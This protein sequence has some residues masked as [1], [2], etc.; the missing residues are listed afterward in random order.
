[1]RSAGVGPDVR[2][3]PVFTVTR[4]GELFVY[5][6]GQGV[7]VLVFGPSQGDQETLEMIARFINDEGDKAWRRR[8]RPH[9]VAWDD[10]RTRLARDLYIDGNTYKPDLLFDVLP[11]EPSLI[12]P[13]R[14]INRSSSPDG[15]FHY[16]NF[17][18]PADEILSIHLGTVRSRVAFTTPVVIP[19]LIEGEPGG[20]SRTWMSHSPHEVFTQRPG[21]RRA[22]GTVLI[23]GLG[24]GWLL[25]R[26]AEKPSVERIIVVEK[27]QGILD[28]VGDKLRSDYPGLMSKVTDW[29]CDDAIAH[30]GRHGLDTR[31]LLDIWEKG[32]DAGHDVAW[33]A[34]KGT[35]RHAWGW[36][37]RQ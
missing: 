36:A 27:D 20:E 6:L 9:A 4:N 2:A 24:L 3:D 19:M 37:E 31:H 16:I 29:I 33:Q 18:M 7:K 5:D 34:A 28:W 32:G 35:V 10:M 12:V 11:V 15:R 1:M 30:V 26:V 13:R 14:K 23:G 21:V 22:T 25:R 8:N 17:L